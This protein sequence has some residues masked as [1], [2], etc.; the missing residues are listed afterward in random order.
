MRAMQVAFMILAMWFA[1]AAV[2]AAQ[3]ARILR[4][5]LPEKAIYI[6]DDYECEAEPILAKL[7]L[8]QWP[9]KKHG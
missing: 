1:F 2:N 5:P 8:Q 7:R 6:E 4:P 3:A 9:N